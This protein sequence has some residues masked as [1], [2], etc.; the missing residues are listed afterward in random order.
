MFQ[1]HEGKVVDTSLQ[2]EVILITS[3]AD[4]RHVSRSL[5]VLEY[6]LLALL[7]CTNRKSSAHHRV[8]VEA[9]PSLDTIE[10]SST[11]IPGNAAKPALTSGSN[12]PGGKVSEGHI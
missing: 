10:G 11:F 12:L 7:H 3:L 6:V 1:K 4:K 8:L 9:S 5:D 2:H